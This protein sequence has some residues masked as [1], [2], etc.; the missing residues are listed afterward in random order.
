MDFSNIVGMIYS[1]ISLGDMSRTWEF[2][3]GFVDQQIM[4]IW[5]NWEDFLWV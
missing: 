3:V 2:F 4:C 5:D 1:D